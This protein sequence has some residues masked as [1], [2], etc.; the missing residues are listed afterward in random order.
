MPTRRP[1]ASP[2]DQLSAESTS[3]TRSASF[4]P[5]SADRTAP[6]SSSIA[7]RISVRSK[8]RSPP[9]STYGTP[10][11]ASARSY[12]S[13]CALT[14]N[15]TAISLA[16]VPASSLARQAAATE[17]A[18]AGSSAYSAKVGSGPASRCPT[19]RSVERRP[20]TRFA[21]CTTCGVDR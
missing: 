13:D 19:S 4:S 14:R 8:N 21:S 15:S 10:A 20:S 7:S 5:D 11:S 3:R 6:R 12:T 9:R 17:A 2:A 18:S 1:P 16:G